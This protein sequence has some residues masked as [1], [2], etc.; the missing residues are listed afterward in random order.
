MPIEI[1]KDESFPYRAVNEALDRCAAEIE[2]QDKFAV[3][4]QF[5]GHEWE[6]EIWARDFDEAHQKCEALRK[7]GKVS[8]RIEGSV[9]FRTT[10]HE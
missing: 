4:F 10:N 6:V 2:H 3:S 9:P 7:T 1:K 8:G 5:D